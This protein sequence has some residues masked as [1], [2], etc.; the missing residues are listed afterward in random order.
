MK[1]A[2]SMPFGTH[3]LD[4]GGVAF[5]LWAPSAQRV[6]LGLRE[7][8]EPQ[9]APERWVS[10]SATGQG[11]WRLEA[12][13]AGPGSRYRFRIDGGWPFPDPAS[14]SNPDDV[15][16]ASEVIDPLAYAWQHPDWRGRPWHE[17][18][19]YELHI[20]TFTPTGTFRAAIERLDYLVE[21][22]IT[23]LELM[24]LADFPGLRDWGYDGV[25]LFAPDA[26]YGRP[27]DLKALI[28]AA[29]GK[30]LMVLLDVVYNHFG[31]EGNYLHLS[32]PA[33]FTERHHTPWGAGL[34]FD[35]ESSR[36]VRDFFIHNALYWLEEYQ[37]DGLRL[38]AVHAFV[39][40]SRPDLL[41]EL[42]AT[43]RTGPGHMR[44]VHLVLE[45]D[46]N[47]AHYLTRRDGQATHYDA[48]WNDDFHHALHV[49]L[50][51]ESDGYYA[52]FAATPIQHL[53]RCLGEG[54]AWQGEASPYRHGE[55]RGEASR[56]LPPNAFVAFLQNH[57][58]IGN[59]AFGERLCQLAEPQ[60]L[61]AAQAVLLLSPQPP[62]LFMGEEFAAA[63][64][65]QFFCD[66]GEELRESVRAGRKREFADFDRFRDPASLAALPDPTQTATFL[67][68][69]LDWSCLDQEHHREWLAYSR[70]LLALRAQLMPHLAEC[71]ALGAEVLGPSALRAAWQLGDG[72]RLTL[73][74]NLGRTPLTGLALPAGPP[75]FATPQPTTSQLTT[76]QPPAASTYWYL[77]ART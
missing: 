10:M 50:T 44:P 54:F 53:A 36:V 19:I 65:F 41:S 42:A 16:A 30:G 77:E 32:A 12:P 74:T 63:T 8:G 58:Q 7:T 14:R 47:A 17:A 13:Q 5:R 61:R 66:F 34:N 11:W 6:E 67:I 37:F 59:R 25:L 21:L 2:H 49:L 69:K 48:Q 43:V 26:S 20:G 60:A 18:V 27:D 15:H 46:H 35:G 71:R 57:D 28:D 4:A 51:G 73:V 24:P 39:D 62:L 64:P 9:I 52:D 3:C 40:D 38:D 76:T 72:R 1:L 23:A 29:H 75:W 33:F 56:H 45:N 22:G 55:P 70:A 68:S 31:P